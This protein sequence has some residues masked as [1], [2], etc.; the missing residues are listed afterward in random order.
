MQLIEKRK[1]ERFNLEIPAT[2]S[3]TT[4]GASKRLELV[5]RDVCSGG[6]YF[7]TKQSPPLGAEE[8]IHLI[9]PLEKFKNLPKRYR[10]VEVNLSGKIMRI[11][12][13]GIGVCFDETHDIRP[14]ENAPTT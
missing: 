9:L 2:V 12:P 11:E 7:K 10:K 6:A 8:R 13:D 14:L 3:M 5:T 1:V 4:G